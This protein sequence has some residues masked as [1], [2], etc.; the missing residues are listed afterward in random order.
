MFPLGPLETN[1]YVAAVDGAAVAVDVGGDPAEVVDYLHTK[2]LSLAAILLTHLHCDHLYGV[3]ALAK[4][5]GAKVLAGGEDAM[6]LDTDL[7]KG[8]FMGLPE[9]PAFSWEPVA[10][11]RLAL[12]GMK[13]DAAPWSVSFFT[14]CSIPPAGSRG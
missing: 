10:P 11:G 7:G 8:G 5:F 1:C 4:E 9:V 2:G 12:P 13:S 14:T 3:A 6:L